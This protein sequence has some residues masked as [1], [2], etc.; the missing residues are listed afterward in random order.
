MK[1]EVVKDDKGVD[2][3]SETVSA[4]ILK[5]GGEYEVKNSAKQ[6]VRLLTSESCPNTPLKGTPSSDESPMTME[7]FKLDA[8]DEI[9]K[10]PELRLPFHMER[11]FE[12]FR[13]CETIVSTLHNRSEICSFDKIK[14][15][16]QEVARW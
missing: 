16:V 11:L 5:Q 2:V 9:R 15:A 1:A 8:T 13:T 10:H 12:L 3:L 6:E 4:V 14:P 7:R